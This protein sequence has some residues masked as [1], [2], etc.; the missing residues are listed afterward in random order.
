MPSTENDGRYRQLIETVENM[1]YERSKVAGVLEILKKATRDEIRMVR[2]NKSKELQ[3][4]KDAEALN[5]AIK[6]YDRQKQ[7]AKKI[8]EELGAEYSKDHHKENKA[9]RKLEKQVDALVISDKVVYERLPLSFY[10][11]NKAL[12]YQ[13]GWDDVNNKDARIHISMSPKY[14]G[15]RKAINGL[16]YLFKGS[17]KITIG[18]SAEDKE[19]MGSLDNFEKVHRHNR[20]QYLHDVS[21]SMLEQ[22]K[23]LGRAEDNIEKKIDGLADNTDRHK[24]HLERAVLAMMAAGFVGGIIFQKPGI[25]GNVVGGTSSGSLSLISIAFFAI[26]IAGMFLYFY[27]NYK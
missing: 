21:E 17:D 20:L 15:L 14:S 9:L 16:G 19:K 11:K 6:G 2:Y 13:E 26:G 1:K 25:T 5:E 23:R 7:K 4:I 10:N 8:I 22:Y 18:G 12:I 3:L 24:T 27:R